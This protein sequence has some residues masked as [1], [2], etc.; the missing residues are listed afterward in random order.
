MVTIID[1]IFAP[2][3]FL[4]PFLFLVLLT[5]P[6][7]LGVLLLDLEA[8]LIIPLISFSR[9]RFEWILRSAYIK[10]TVAAS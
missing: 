9:F 4:P 2:P 3:P 10:R 1:L 6:P 8:L 7:I 5:L